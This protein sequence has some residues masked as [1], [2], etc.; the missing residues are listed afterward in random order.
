MRALPALI[1]T[2]SVTL[3]GCSEGD[4]VVGTWTFD[5]E[6]SAQILE[7]ELARVAPG[8]GR[9]GLRKKAL[10][11]IKDALGGLE[12]TLELKDGGEAESTGQRPGRGP[13]RPFKGE[14]T[15]DDRKNELLVTG[16]GSPQRYVLK[17]DV[18]H[19]LVEVPEGSKSR[20]LRL[21]MKRGA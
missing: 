1:L 20:T 11:M 5:L 18:L 17:G 4:K 7:P 21:V 14:W 3:A 9:E 2:I 16:K 8:A 15:F 13:Q 6:A 19:Y 12:I 10:A